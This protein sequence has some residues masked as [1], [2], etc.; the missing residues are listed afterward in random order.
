M[1]AKIWPVVSLT[2]AALSLGPS[3]A[4]V[5]EAGPRLT[6]WPPEL[7]IEA[8]VRHGQFALFRL[9]GAPIDVAAIVAAA[10]L[11][12][13]YRRT[14]G[15]RASLAATVL[16]A[17]AL[18]AWFGLVAPANTLLAAW[19]PGPPPPDFAVVRDRWESGHMVVA[20]LKLLGLVA[21]SSA[22]AARAGR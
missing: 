6:V 9:I 3:F 1:L 13:T 8:T 16:L 20:A 22:V 2:L 15:F 12:W 5:L 18:G 7:W 19:R 21:M 14:A 17:L 4:H 11:A 10:A